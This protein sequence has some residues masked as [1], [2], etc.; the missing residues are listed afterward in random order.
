MASFEV[1]VLSEQYNGQEKRPT[2]C[3]RKKILA[4]HSLIQSW[5]KISNLNYWDPLYLF[6]NTYF[7]RLEMNNRE[8]FILFISVVLC[9]LTARE[10]SAQCTQAISITAC[11]CSSDYDCNDSCIPSPFD[12]CT[13]LGKWVGFTASCTGTYT[14]TAMIAS[15]CKQNCRSCVRICESQRDVAAV[16]TNCGSAQNSVTVDLVQGHTYTLHVCKLACQDHSCSECSTCP[17]TGCVTIGG[18]A[19]TQKNCNAS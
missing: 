17:A 14:V 19:C 4:A 18:G 8:T 13:D 11:D 7:K 12:D 5:K 3:G 2:I 10:L 15:G 6:P 1:N 9:L 16:S